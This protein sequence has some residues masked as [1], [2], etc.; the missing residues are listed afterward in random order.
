MS[1]MPVGYSV[2]C[3]IVAIGR[4]NRLRLRTVPTTGVAH[5][6]SHGS[7]THR[8]ASLLEKRVRYAQ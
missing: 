1:A 4:D 3:P 8:F 7:M 2:D 6:S 5:H